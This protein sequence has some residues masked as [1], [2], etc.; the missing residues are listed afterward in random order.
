MTINYK[1]TYTYNTIIGC[2]SFIS[3]KTN[4]VYSVNTGPHGNNLPVT[5]ET[6]ICKQMYVTEHFHS[7]G[8][9][10]NKGSTQLFHWKF[11]D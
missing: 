3:L 2:L 7:I 6:T 4:S 9:K 1:Y 5:G 11:Q 10:G 8:Q